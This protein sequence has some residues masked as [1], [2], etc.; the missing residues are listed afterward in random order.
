MKT[1]GPIKYL[2][3]RRTEKRGVRE[4]C[5]LMRRIASHSPIRDTNEYSSKRWGKC[6]NK[7]RFSSFSAEFRWVFAPM[8]IRE[9]EVI[10]I[11]HVFRIRYFFVR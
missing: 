9:R 2:G 3:I 7:R 4:R 11:L 5:G 8:Q 6:V 10:L 1:F